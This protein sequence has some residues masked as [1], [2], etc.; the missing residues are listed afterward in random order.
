MKRII[1]FLFLVALYARS[2]AQE[3]V[4]MHP[5]WA[6]P[7]VHVMFGEYDLYFT[8]HDI[9]RAM[10]FL[11]DNQQVIYGK[12]SGLDTGAT[13]NIQLLAGRQVQYRTTL[14]PLIQNGVGAF[15]LLSGRAL[16]TKRGK[17]QKQITAE[18]GPAVDL[19]GTYTMSVNFYDCRTHQMLFSGIMDAS[20]YHKDLGFE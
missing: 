18:P 19:N 16:I 15:I 6:H 4:K 9:N 2:P 7:Q 13:Y 8:I 14:E 17:T 5:L 10:S 3:I 11:P 20:L 12:T 1:T